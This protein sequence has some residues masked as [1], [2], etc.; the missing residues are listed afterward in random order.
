MHTFLSVTV[1][2]RGPTN[3]RGARFLVDTLSGRTV[4][5]P[6]DYDARDA[7]RAAF[8]AAAVKDPGGIP[9]GAW[10]KVEIPEGRAFVRFPRP[11]PYAQG[12]TRVVLAP[13][14]AVVIRHK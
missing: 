6:Y 4:T 2:Y 14:E 12:S 7:Y 1:R 11:E 9:A 3:A 10:I 5:I 8:E 13:D